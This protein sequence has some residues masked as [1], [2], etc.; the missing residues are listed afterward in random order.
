MSGSSQNGID[1][2]HQVDENM[3]RAQERDASTKQSF[4][5]RR[6]VFPPDRIPQQYDLNSRPVSPPSSSIPPS[7]TSS[8]PTSVQF[9]GTR[10]LNGNSEGSSRVNQIRTGE[11][12]RSHSRSSTVNTD[13]SI[14]D[15]TEGRDGGPCE[16]VEMTMNEI[17]N[18]REEGFPGLMGVVNAYL[19]SLNVDLAT[20]CE[21]RR[22]LDLI[23]LRAKGECGV[24]CLRG[25]ETPG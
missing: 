17:I 1:G 5:F 14:P 3:Q 16:S 15:E 22:Y 4:H 12:E 10:D 21:L 11:N 2:S 24:R 20:K 8:R 19:N 13:C 7:P 6:N 25:K 18:G 23:K 9:N